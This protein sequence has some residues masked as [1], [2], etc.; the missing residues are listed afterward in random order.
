MIVR[1]LRALQLYMGI[2]LAIFKFGR[3]GLVT[4][5]KTLAI[6]AISYGLVAEPSTSMLNG[7]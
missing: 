7:I 1:H 2:F 3:A 5:L 6:Q 4:P